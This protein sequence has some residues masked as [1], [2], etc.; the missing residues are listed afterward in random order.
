MGFNGLPAPL[1]HLWH[2]LMLLA[3]RSPP[4]KNVTLPPTLDFA[5]P[6]KFQTPSSGNYLKAPS[7][8]STFP[9]DSHGLLAS[10]STTSSTKNIPKC[11]PS[12]SLPAQQ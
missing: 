10:S 5:D 2:L 9:V 4:G 1:R 12:I 11:P 8:F 6:T 7:F 3:C